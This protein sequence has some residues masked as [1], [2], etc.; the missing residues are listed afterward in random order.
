[1]RMM[2]VVGLLFG[3]VACTPSLQQNGQQLK[4]SD[5]SP[6]VR[7]VNLSGQAVR[8]SAYSGQ[9]LLVNAWGVW[10]GPCRAEIPTLVKL[11]DKYRSAGLKIIGIDVLDRRERLDAFLKDNPLNYETWLEGEGTDSVRR[12]LDTWE[13]YGNGSI[14]VPFTFSVGRDGRVAG[15]F[16]DSD[17]SGVE[18][19]KLIVAALK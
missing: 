5:P 3:L 17:P 1:M 4:E 19:E 2:L 6:E 15:V 11:Q 13:S 8:L 16:A 12:L 9:P 10:C 7:L 18:L 14:S